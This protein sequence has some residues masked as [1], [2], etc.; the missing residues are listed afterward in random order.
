MNPLEAA[1]KYREES[2]SFWYQKS[3]SLYASASLIRDGM[4][5]S[6]EREFIKGLGLKSEFSLELGCLDNYLMMFGLSYEVMLKA[7]CIEKSINFEKSHKI[8]ELAE[9]AKIVLIENESLLLKLLSEYV[10]WEGRYPVPKNHRFMTEHWDATRNA[11]WEEGK[12]IGGIS[13]TGV[14]EYESLK[15]LWLKLSDVYFGLRALKQRSQ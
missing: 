7:I 15:S 1:Y 9:Q 10:I 4:N 5:S 13:R 11:L 12:E 8:Q 14:F 6:K 3:V 2:S